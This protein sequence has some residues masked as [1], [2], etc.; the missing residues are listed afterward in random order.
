MT[1]RAGTA[2]SRQIVQQVA[3]KIPWFHSVVLLDKIKDAGT[4]LWYARKAHE[5]GWSRNVLT[6]QIEVRLHERTGRAITNFPATLPPG[7]SD[8]ATEVFKDPYL[9]DFLGTAASRTEREIEQALVDHMR[10]STVPSA[11]R[12][13]RTSGGSPTRPDAGSRPCGEGR[14]NGRRRHDGRPSTGEGHRAIRGMN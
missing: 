6:M 11:R 3:A 7:D 2:A 13:V 14:A 4:R 10:R 1:G 9:F 12:A 5:E 8:M